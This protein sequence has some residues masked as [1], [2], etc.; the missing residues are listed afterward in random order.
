[1]TIDDLF[2]NASGE[3]YEYS[4]DLMVTP[5]STAKEIVKDYA[6]SILKELSE[7]SEICCN[8]FHPMVMKDDIER[9]IKEIQE[10]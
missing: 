9:K 4:Y 8:N 10:I 7:S 3:A 1:M 5:L 2:K 6:I